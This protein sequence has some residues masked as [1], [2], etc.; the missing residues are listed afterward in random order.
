[1]THVQVDS[2]EVTPAM[3]EAGKHALTEAVGAQGNFD[4][5]S[6]AEAAEVVFKSMIAACSNDQVPR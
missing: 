3:I 4:W 1:M 2:I 6:H 5:A